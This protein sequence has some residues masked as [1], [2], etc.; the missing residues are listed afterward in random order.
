M[1]IPNEAIQSQIEG[2]ATLLILDDEVRKISTIR[3]FGF[4]VTN[5]THRLISYHT[6]CFWEMHK[7]IGVHLVSQSG[8]AELDVHAPTNQ[9]LKQKIQTLADTPSSKEVRQYR[10]EEL[11]LG[12]DDL[13]SVWP[14]ALP[15]FLLWCPLLSKSGVLTGGIVFFNDIEFTDS[16]IKMLKWL[17]ASY[18]YTWTVLTKP[19]TLT[20]WTEFRKKRY[21]RPLVIG[22]IIIIFFPIR[23]T[24]HGTGTVVPKD[25][26]LINSPL[27]G[28]I[29]SFAVT[30]G[31]RVKNGQLLITFDQTDLKSTLEVDQRNIQLTQAK[32]RTVINEGFNDKTKRSEVPVLQAQLAID[33]AHFDYT[34]NLLAKTELKS[35]ISGVVI[36]DSREDWVG[37]PVHT[38]ERI[39]EVAN[40]DQVKLRITIPIADVIRLELGGK[41]DFFL[42]GKLN[43]MP[44]S[45]TSLGYNAKLLPNKVLAY[46][47]DAEFVN[48]NDSPQI[49]AQGSVSLYGNHVPFIYYLIRRPLQALRQ[50]LGI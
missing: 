38:G 18:Q 13:A 30:P 24:T 14:E 19:V 37:Q 28:V 21:F 16:E 42:F 12:T 20:T 43:S 47:Y 17:I 49:G 4:F 35:P 9:W 11:E 8:I 48:Q 10:A 40:P 41:G 32:L 46:Q 29:Q 44:V 3:E 31:E 22:I 33:Q 1:N 2:L 36:F 7:M 45:L 5:E 39:L 27:Q 6:A 34:N 26:I 50:L 15:R 25:P 23:I